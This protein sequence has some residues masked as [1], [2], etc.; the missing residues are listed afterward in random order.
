MIQHAHHEHERDFLLQKLDEITR[1]QEEE[2]RLFVEKQNQERELFLQARMRMLTSTLVG[3]GAGAGVGVRWG[4]G[5]VGSHSVLS[6]EWV[7]ACPCVRAHTYDPPLML[8]ARVFE[9][10]RGMTRIVYGRVWVW[11]ESCMV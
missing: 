11:Q 6:Y 4:V 7:N 1:K 9:F 10:V 8:A 3:T 5:E 2:R